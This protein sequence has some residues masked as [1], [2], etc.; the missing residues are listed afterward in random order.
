MTIEVIFHDSCF[1][2]LKWQYFYSLFI[3]S[4]H[5]ALSLSTGISQKLLFLSDYSVDDEGVI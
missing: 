5:M 2:I 1:L 4:P 3:I